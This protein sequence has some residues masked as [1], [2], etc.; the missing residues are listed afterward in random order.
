MSTAPTPADAGMLAQRSSTQ[1]SRIP[2]G[3]PFETPGGQAKNP[4]A[5]GL[6]ICPPAGQHMKHPRN[7]SLSS[8]ET[9][10]TGVMS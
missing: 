4:G 10:S 3:G 6:P 9:A 8:R 7:R 1:E 5:S 2:P